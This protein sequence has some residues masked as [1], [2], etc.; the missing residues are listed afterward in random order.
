MSSEY[1]VGCFAAARDVQYQEMQN[2]QKK[3]QN[4]F[5]FLQIPRL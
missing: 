3:Q 4:K 5:D 2:E 1:S